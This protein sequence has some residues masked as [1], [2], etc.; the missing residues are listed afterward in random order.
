M[1]LWHGYCHQQH[2]RQIKVLLK[3]YEEKL[4][5]IYMEEVHY[6]VTDRNWNHVDTLI[7][8]QVT[9]ANPMSYRLF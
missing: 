7:K 1:T 9:A 8:R 5:A 4:Q 3:L 2:G 6:L